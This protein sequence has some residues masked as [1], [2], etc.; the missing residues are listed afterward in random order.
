MLYQLDA[1]T[2]EGNQWQDPIASLKET[3][4]QH[5]VQYLRDNGPMPQQPPDR[6][7]VPLTENVNESAGSVTTQKEEGKNTLILNVVMIAFTVFCMNT[8][9]DKYASPQMYG[10]CPSWALAWDNRKQL[11]LTE[12]LSNGTDIICL[13]VRLHCFFLSFWS[14]VLTTRPFFFNL[15]RKSKQDNSMT[16]SCPSSLTTAT[17][18]SSGICLH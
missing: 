4:T 15:F 14:S 2:L 8:L 13:Q 9:C 6:P 5:I 12:L 3:S 10:Y 11:I 1:L 16:F 17:T 7:W 18:A